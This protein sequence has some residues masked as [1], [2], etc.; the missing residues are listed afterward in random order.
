MALMVTVWPTA[1]LPPNSSCAVSDPSTTTAAR[2]EMSAASRNLPPERVRARTESQSGWLPTTEVVQFD[3]PAVNGSDVETVG[4]TALMSGATVLSAS[5]AA[6]RTVNV[7]AE[8]NPP[9]MPELLVE[10]PGE[11]ISR[12]LPRALI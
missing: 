7:D 11:T 8:P 1:E 10:L 6:S 3:E 2:E 12:L 5:A 9:R 4:A